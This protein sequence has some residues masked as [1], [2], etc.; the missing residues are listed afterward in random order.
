MALGDQISIDEILPPPPGIEAWRAR[1]AT[2]A[3]QRIESA[4][5]LQGTNVERQ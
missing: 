2:E 4:D 5:D 3:Q 1:M